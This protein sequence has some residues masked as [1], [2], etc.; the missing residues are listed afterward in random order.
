[1]TPVDGDPRS[2]AGQRLLAA[3]A[4]IPPL[5]AVVWTWLV[6]Q[7]EP[8]ID[9][10]SAEYLAAAESLLAGQGWIGVDGQPYVL[11]GPL[12]PVLLAALQGLGLG[13]LDAVRALN[14]ASAAVI[15]WAC[16]ALVRRV[17]G[18]RA[19]AIFGAGAG[20]VA[21]VILSPMA[22]SEPVFTALAAAALLGW[23]AY[24]R[25]PT[26]GRLAGLG[27][28]SGLAFAQRYAGAAL[29]GTTALFVLLAPGA[30]RWR[31]R[32]THALG[33]LA[34]AGLPTAAWAVRNALVAGE[35]LGERGV[36]PSK[37]AFDLQ[38]AASELLA[39]AHAPRGWLG[40]AVAAVPLA[41]MGAGAVVLLR[42]PRGTAPVRGER[43]LV[44][45]PVAWAAAL[46]V[47][48]QVTVVDEI[49]VRLMAPAMPFV[50][51]TGVVGAHALL[52][53]RWR[54]PAAAALA[55]WGALWA[56]PTL[57]LRAE[58]QLATI[59]T[60]GPGTFNTPRWRES[61]TVAAIAAA[62]PAGE[63]YCNIPA[64][65][66][67]LAGL[68]LRSLPGREAGFVRL[69]RRW[70][71]E[72]GERSVIW[73]LPTRGAVFPHELL[74]Q[75]LVARRTETWADGELWEVR[76]AGPSSP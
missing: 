5:V 7:P 58:E 56:V 28:L 65:L 72:P 60:A 76:S 19:A 9:D 54:W 25:D 37:L 35:P 52:R 69:G 15:S 22:W 36:L 74:G 53:S 61:E 66:Y 55:A 46:V 33:Y 29:V 45:F 68:R 47:T 75:E 62:P 1:L 4:W 8:A 70:A 39:F 12:Y 48:R 34:L 40:Y 27:V 24:A 38:C 17:T 20:L 2:G 31:V 23:L 3:A 67:V 16:G 13:V 64:A 63:V 43:I 30:A 73:F 41:C 10:D 57:S 6:T 18:S 21:G 44:V 26:P 42:A 71:R 11:W 49:D 59:A 32:C 50:A 51:A 14:A